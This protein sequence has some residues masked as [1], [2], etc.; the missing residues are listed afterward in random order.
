MKRSSPGLRGWVEKRPAPAV[1]IVDGR[2][3]VRAVR[4]TWRR[5][6]CGIVDRGRGRRGVQGGVEVEKGD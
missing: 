2:V 3:V 4:G 6:F 5:G 1:G